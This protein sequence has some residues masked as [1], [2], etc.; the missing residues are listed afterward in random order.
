VCCND[1]RRRRRRNAA[2]VI[3]KSSFSL[4]AKRCWFQISTRNGRQSISIHVGSRCLVPFLLSACV[5]QRSEKKEKKT[6]EGVA[7]EEAEAEE[8]RKKTRTRSTGTLVCGVVVENVWIGGSCML[9][10]EY[11][12]L[13]EESGHDLLLC[14]WEFAFR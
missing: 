7:A 4:D 12:G 3:L 14:I 8:K 1:L 6:E 13:Q 10:R 11:S 9:G 2:E 5:L